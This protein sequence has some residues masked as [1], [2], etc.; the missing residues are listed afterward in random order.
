MDLLVCG[1]TFPVKMSRKTL[2]QLEDNL[3]SVEEYGVEEA[4]CI[5]A[6]LNRNG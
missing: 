1:F 2:S 4:G 3:E 5:Q 6:K